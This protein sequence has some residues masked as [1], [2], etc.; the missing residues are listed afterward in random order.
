MCSVGSSIFAHGLDT[1]EEI[2]AR[3]ARDANGAKGSKES[4]GKCNINHEEHEEHEGR[5][6]IPARGSLIEEINARDARDAKD[7]KGN[8][9]VPLLRWRGVCLV[10]RPSVNVISTRHANPACH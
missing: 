5:G 10:R 3:D 9:D 2:N 1:E 8:I 7:A 4:T 6:N